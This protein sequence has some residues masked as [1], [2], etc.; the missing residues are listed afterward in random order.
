MEPIDEKELARQQLEK[1]VMVVIEAAYKEKVE[2]GSRS[3]FDA[4]ELAEI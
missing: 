3:S 4:T 2:D 1:D